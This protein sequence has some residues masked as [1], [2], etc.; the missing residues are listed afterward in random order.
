[1]SDFCFLNRL[2]LVVELALNACEVQEDGC[3]LRL[4]AEV[5]VRTERQHPDHRILLVNISGYSHICSLK[6]RTK[7]EGLAWG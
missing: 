1:M 2:A 4:N 7:A 6:T 3:G 5:A